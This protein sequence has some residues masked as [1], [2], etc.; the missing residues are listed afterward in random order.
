MGIPPLAAIAAGAVLGTF[1]GSVNGL[2]VTKMR[3]QPFIA[4]LGTMSVFR[5]IAYVVTGSPWAER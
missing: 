4:T 5:G 2:L 3:L 1:M